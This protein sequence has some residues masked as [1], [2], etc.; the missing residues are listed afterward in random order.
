MRRVDELREQTVWKSDPH[1][2]VKHL[3]YRHYLQCWM[4]KFLQTFPE[5]TIVDAFA[6]PGVY[7]DGPPGSPIVVAKRRSVRL[8]EVEAGLLAPAVKP[9]GG[10]GLH[11]QV[12]GAVHPT[13]ATAAHV[14]GTV[15]ARVVGEVADYPY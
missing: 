14:R 3:V 9:S 11:V 12:V 1:T 15:R 13:G 6:G 7:T 8:G 2:Q 10:R 5:A 4:R